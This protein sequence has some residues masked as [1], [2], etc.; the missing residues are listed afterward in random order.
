MTKAIDKFFDSVYCPGMICKRC[1]K[2]DPNDNGRYELSTSLVTCP[3][4]LVTRISRE[5][6]PNL[7]LG[8]GFMKI[9][10]DI[11]VM[12]PIDKGHEDMRKGVVMGFCKSYPYSMGLARSGNE[13]LPSTDTLYVDEKKDYGE[14]EALYFCE[15]Y[16]EKRDYSREINLASNDALSDCSFS[17]L[18]YQYSDI[19]SISSS[20]SS[21]SPI[22][23][24]DHS[25]EEMVSLTNQRESTALKPERQDR[26]THNPS[27]DEINHQ[28]SK[29]KAKKNS[30]SKNHDNIINSPSSSH[31]H[32]QDSKDDT[33]LPIT[34]SRKVFG[35]SSEHDDDEEGWTTKRSKKQ[36]RRKRRRG[37]KNHRRVMYLIN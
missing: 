16:D 6:K 11:D 30:K 17:S 34:S 2:E 1:N 14:S 27:T 35:Q 19:G 21:L 33:F 28:K 18:S 22:N 4:I 10:D 32:G 9:L 25:T 36:L 24:Y 5:K 26:G 37:L 8:E 12:S 3:K 31:D 20:S 13:F 15:N 29:K 7:G 23:D